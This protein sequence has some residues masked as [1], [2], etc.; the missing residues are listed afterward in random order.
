M[1]LVMCTALCT[2]MSLQAG[3]RPRDVVRLA[4]SVATAELDRDQ[5]RQLC[6]QMIQ[7]LAEHAP[8]RVIQ[9]VPDHEA[10]SDQI[11]DVVVILEVI[12]TD[13][14]DLQLRLHWQIAPEAMRQ[15]GPS[16]AFDAR[17]AGLSASALK[18][19][20]DE[21]LLITPALSQAFAP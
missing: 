21:L 17:R 3:N 10:L 14:A 1:V 11:E 9:P 20:T 4:C 18:K 12:G 13:P 6:Q 16:I 15:I 19:I 8:G 2:D 5:A 7:T